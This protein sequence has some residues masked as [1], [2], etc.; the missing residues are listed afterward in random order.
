MS[1]VDINRIPTPLA[2]PAAQ[3]WVCCP[4]EAP[5]LESSAK[6]MAMGIT[7]KIRKKE[8]EPLRDSLLAIGGTLDTNVY[9]RPVDRRLKPDS[10]RRTIYDFVDRANI[11]DVLVNFDF[12]TA[13]FHHHQK[14]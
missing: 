7:M 13:I 14:K 12:A 4:Q 5:L 3:L 9:G 10:T 11:A 1:S 6:T 2:A 8:V